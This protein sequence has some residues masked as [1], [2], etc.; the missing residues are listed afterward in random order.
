MGSVIHISKNPKTWLCVDE[1]AHLKEKYGGHPLVKVTY[2][3][4]DDYPSNGPLTILMR[5]EIYNRLLD[6]EYKLSP[7]KN[8]LVILDRA[9]TPIPP[10]VED[11]IY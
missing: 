9:N 3:S 2:G 6:G 1:G 7:A 8:A 5:T 4:L 10:I 11:F